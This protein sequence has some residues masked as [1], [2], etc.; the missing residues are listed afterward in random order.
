MS[1]VVQVVMLGYTATSLEIGDLPILS[2]SMRATYIF[3]TMK[4]AMGAFKLKIG[5]WKP[6]PGAGW[7]IAYRLI[8]LNAHLLALELSLA[9]VAAL[10]F[11]APAFFLRKLVFYLESDPERTKI[12]WGIVFS[13]GLFLSNAICQTSECIFCYHPP[14]RL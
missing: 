6:S 12:S 10:L 11:Y 5:N 13:V 8:R 1:H 3:S 7:D 9:V 2:A 14:L 4:H